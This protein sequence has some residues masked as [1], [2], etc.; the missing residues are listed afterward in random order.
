M[1]G[2]SRACFFRANARGTGSEDLVNC[3]D[4]PEA[5]AKLTLRPKDEPIEM[6]KPPAGAGSRRVTVATA[7]VPPPTVIG[8][9]VKESSLPPTSIDW[10]LEVRP[11]GFFT[12]LDNPPVLLS[13]KV[14]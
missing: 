8:V 14:R 11:D 3:E 10:P 4:K 5:R 2:Q 9:T 12:V 1:F 13:C 6:V 7:S